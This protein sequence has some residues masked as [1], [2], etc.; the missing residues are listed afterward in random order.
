LL[1]ADLVWLTLVLAAATAMA[2]PVPN[3]MPEAF[4]RPAMRTR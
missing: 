4:G 2:D 1:M 3:T